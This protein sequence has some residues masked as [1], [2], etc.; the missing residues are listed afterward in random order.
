MALCYV[1]LGL[2]LFNRIFTETPVKKGTFGAKDTQPFFKT[3][4]V[5]SGVRQVSIDPAMEGSEAAV[6]T[7]QDV[8]DVIQLAKLNPED[9]LSVTQSL[10]FSQELVDPNSVK[11]MEVTPELADQLES[12]SRQ[13]IIRGEAGDSAV[14][15]SDVQTFDL[16][17]AETS[18]SV[19]LLEGLKYPDQCKRE[20]RTVTECQVTGNE[21]ILSPKII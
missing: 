17:E 2:N 18:N 10:K 9:F 11:L 15:C 12:G 21:I 13:V 1:K 4:Q 8:D 5:L 7:V 3:N 20:Q 6:R 14:L 16:R 19:L